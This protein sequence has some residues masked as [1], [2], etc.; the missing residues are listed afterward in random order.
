MSLFQL[1]EVN[2]AKYKQ[3]KPGSIWRHKGV[4]DI[5]LKII[6]TNLEDKVSLVRRGHLYQSIYLNNVYLL[7]MYEPCEDSLE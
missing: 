3:L 1:Y 5:K 4:P 7:D 2:K 6:S